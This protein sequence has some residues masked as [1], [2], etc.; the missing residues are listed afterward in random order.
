MVNACNWTAS[1]W[2]HFTSQKGKG[3][4]TSGKNQWGPWLHCTQHLWIL[5][6]YWLTTSGRTECSLRLPQVVLSLSC[7][8]SSSTKSFL[9]TPNWSPKPPCNTELFLTYR[10]VVNTV[11]QWIAD[12][13]ESCYTMQYEAFQISEV[14][15]NTGD[16]VGDC[17]WL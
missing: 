7:W 12:R 17:I 6:H 16:S 15:F 5:I 14:E 1:G 9:V 2:P 10:K 4:S 13:S 8:G 11:F 3:Y